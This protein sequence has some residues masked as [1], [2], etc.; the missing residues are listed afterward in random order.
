[1]A[2]KSV[3][4]LIAVVVIAAVVLMVLRRTN[5]SD[6]GVKLIK[7]ERGTIVDKALAIGRIDPDNEIA[8]KSKISSLVDLFEALWKAGHTI[9]I[10]THDPNLPLRTE[11]T[12][13][14]RDGLISEGA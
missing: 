10:I 13:T 1:M 2:R 8:I 4:A 3:L 6:N 7:V 11:R 9:M 5:G 12:I 14:M